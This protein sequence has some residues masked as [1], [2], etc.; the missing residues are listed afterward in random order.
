M[1]ITTFTFASKNG[2]C[3]ECRAYGRKWYIQDRAVGTGCYDYCLMSVTTEPPKAYQFKNL[4]EVAAWLNNSDQLES[5]EVW[6]GILIRRWTI[7]DADNLALI[8]KN[9]VQYRLDKIAHTLTELPERRQETGWFNSYRECLTEAKD[10]LRQKSHT[11]P[12][13]FTA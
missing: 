2:L 11:Q 3:P 8:E 12:S 10:I 9:G 6:V 1:S 4:A 7:A 13:R 5:D